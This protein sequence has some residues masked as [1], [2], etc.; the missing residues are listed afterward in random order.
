MITWKYFKF[1]F[2]RPLSI[3]CIVMAFWLR[4]AIDGRK[5][6]KLQTY[7][8]P[9]SNLIF[10]FFNTLPAECV[11]LLFISIYVR[12]TFS[13]CY[14]GLCFCLAE[15]LVGKTGV[16]GEK[17]TA[18]GKRGFVPLKV[19]RGSPLLWPSQFWHLDWFLFYFFVVC[20]FNSGKGELGLDIYLVF[21]LVNEG[22]ILPTLVGLK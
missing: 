2:R 15:I 9:R 22:F 17:N 5:H 3:T 13:T 6:S 18:R 20:Y 21:S 16:L 8:D 14:M 1:N 12:K 10:T 7:R 11:P 4:P 19:R